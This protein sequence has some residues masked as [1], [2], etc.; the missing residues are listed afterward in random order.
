MNLGDSIAYFVS[1]KEEIK[2]TTEHKPSN[3]NEYALL[4]SK[5]AQVI[6][7]KNNVLRIQ[8][9][10]AVTRAFGDIQYKKFITSEPEVIKVCLNDLKY[11]YLIL[12]T[13]GFW[14]VIIK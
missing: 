12:A 11:E 13:D 6:G 7:N 3:E 1:E 9:Q 5:D 4:M 2:L 10:L 14:N 8:G